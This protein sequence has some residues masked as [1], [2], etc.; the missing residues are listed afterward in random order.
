MLMTQS[1]VRSSSPAAISPQSPF[2]LQTNANTIT[3]PFTWAR[4]THHAINYCTRI[5]RALR[6]LWMK[7]VCLRQLEKLITADISEALPVEKTNFQRILIWCL[8]KINESIGA[9]GFQQVRLADCFKGQESNV[10]S[11][12]SWEQTLLSKSTWGKVS[13]WRRRWRETG[14]TPA[15]SEG[16]SVV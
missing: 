3:V 15:E 12:S 14:L 4:G 5:N 13:P 16:E 9:P 1:G 10:T 8:W 6:W 7:C 2:V 11:E